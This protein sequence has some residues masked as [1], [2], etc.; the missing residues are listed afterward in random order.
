MDLACCRKD[1][2]RIL[3]P[4]H[5]WRRRVLRLLPTLRQPFPLWQEGQLSDLL[6]CRTA[7]R[8]RVSTPARPLREG[9]AGAVA[10]GRERG[11]GTSLGGCQARTPW[12]SVTL[13]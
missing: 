9:A 10:F 6:S 4:L 8:F 3:N 2:L 7:R 12:C 11:R 1:F 5:G 13:G